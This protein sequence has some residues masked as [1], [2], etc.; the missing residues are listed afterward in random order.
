M[1][2]QIIKTITIAV[3][4]L[5][6]S[7]V[8]ANAQV[9]SRVLVTLPFDFHIKDRT[10][11]AG[12]YVL[13]SL[14]PQSSGSTIAFRRMDG[15]FNRSVVMN[16]VG[17]AQQKPGSASLIFNRYGS[18]YYLSEI[19]NPAEELSMTAPVTKTERELAARQKAASETVAMG[20]SRH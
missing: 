9:H 20:R 14:N 1:K 11:P 12:V 4:I 8:S 5:V 19:R 2:S 16:P 15:K 17:S 7:F 6:G 3:V 18:E 10:L 13:E